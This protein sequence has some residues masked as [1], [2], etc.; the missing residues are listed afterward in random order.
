MKTLRLIGMA[1]F[2][3]LMCVNFASCSNDDSVEPN[4]SQN[5]KEYM[6]SLGFSGEINVSESPLSRAETEE[7]NDLYGFVI[8]SCPNVEGQTKYTKYAY[9]LFDDVSSVNIKLLDGYKYKFTSTMIVNGKKIVPIVGDEYKWPFLMRLTNS[10]TYSSASNLIHCE[11]GQIGNPGYYRAEADRYYGKLIDFIP[12]DEN[13]AAVL[14]MKRIVFGAKFIAEN[15]NEGQLTISMEDA[16]I[17]CL[18]PEISTSDKIYTLSGV[19]KAFDTDDYFEEIPTVINWKKADG[20]IVPLGEHKINFKR[21]KLTTITIKVADITS[22]NNVS[23]ELEDEEMGEGDDI[24]IEN[25]K[26][27]DTNIGTET[28]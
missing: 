26:I 25:G 15:L 16:P 10:F 11:G 6:V 23:V 9:G 4:N 22:D 7:N 2:A 14:Y 5:P 19:E 8:Y 13:N 17:V 20:V 3:V 24:T 12:S 1:L 21:N 18:T 27:V 28:E